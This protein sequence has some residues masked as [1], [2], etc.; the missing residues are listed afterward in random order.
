MQNLEICC[1]ASIKKFENDRTFG[2][3]GAI[4]IGSNEQMYKV[5]PDS[6][7]NRS[8]C[9][10]V[11][12]A[13]RLANEMRQKTNYDNITIYSDS[14]F[15]VYGLKEWLPKWLSTRDQNGIMYNYNGKP[16]INQELFLAIVSYLVKNDLKVRFL[17]QKGHVNINSGKDMYIANKVFFESNGFFMNLDKIKQIS[18][19]NNII[20]NNTRIKLNEDKSIDPI[21][22]PIIKRNMDYDIMCKYM[23]P[24]NYKDFIL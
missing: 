16:V 2:C 21:N 1:D 17:H 13:V 9:I 6:T 19:Y 15:A 4:V 12:L 20:D 7:N 5:L 10:A 22:T 14:K 8:E 18:Y 11:L 24:R 23:I 3:A